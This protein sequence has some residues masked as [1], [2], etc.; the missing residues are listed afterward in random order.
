MQL[1]VESI[2]AQLDT[3][4]F[5]LRSGILSDTTCDAIVRAMEALAPE[6]HSRES[7]Y[8]L[9]DPL[10]AAPDLLPILASSPIPALA[11]TL[12]QR[13]PWVVRSLYYDKP[14]D[15]KWKEPWQQNRTVT[16]RA[17]GEPREFKA[18]SMKEGI[19][20]ALAPVSLLKRMVIVRIHLD[21]CDA[22]NGALHVIPGTHKKGLL[23]DK[24]MLAFRAKEGEV[25]CAIPR[26]G[27]MLMKPLLA[28]SSQLANP[29]RHRRVLH[30]EFADSAPATA[31]EWY[32]TL[33]LDA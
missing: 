20:H 1:D 28:H 9:R 30:L 7:A 23:G 21:D 2:Q 26:G 24:D 3:R 25:I 31:L 33:S 6:T 5:C 22:K 17:H 15:T 8:A 4:G 16:L 10:I 13:S 14:I 12:F 18:W 27:V 32:S 11:A 19:P 29:P